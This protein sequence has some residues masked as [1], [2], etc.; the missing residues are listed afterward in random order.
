MALIII[1]QCCRGKK[2]DN[3]SSIQQNNDQN[4]TEHQ[5]LLPHS[6][7]HNHS[8]TGGHPSYSVLRRRLDQVSPVIPL[9][10]EAECILEA[11]SLPDHGRKLAETHPS[12]I[13]AEDPWG[14]PGLN[15]HSIWWIV[16]VSCLTQIIWIYVA[17]KIYKRCVQSKRRSE[18][19]PLHELREITVRRWV[20]SVYLWYFL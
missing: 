2:D 4:A 14:L 20:I 1:V 19:A 9:A 12:K 10:H 3:V 18:N 17:Y 13:S 11:S 8:G 7:S 16:P 15:D 5:P 6:N